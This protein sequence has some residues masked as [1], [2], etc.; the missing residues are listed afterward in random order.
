MWYR[1]S[2][3]PWDWW[4]ACRWK[5]CAEVMHLWVAPLP[6]CIIHFWWRV[7][8]LPVRGEVRHGYAR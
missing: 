8:P 7:R 3:S 6:M 1:A 5:E 4:V 2:F